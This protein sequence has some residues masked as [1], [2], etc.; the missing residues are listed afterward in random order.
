[1]AVPVD[2]HGVT[3]LRFYGRAE[4]EGAPESP[5]PVIPVLSVVR[6]A[7][8]RATGKSLDDKLAARLKDKIAFVSFD[9]AACER[10]ETPTV[11]SSLAASAWASALDNLL[12]S[13]GLLRASADEDAAVAFVMALLG[14]LVSLLYTRGPHPRRTV[15]FVVAAA[16]LVSVGYLTWMWRSY[17]AGL[18]VGAVIP[19]LAFVVTLVGAT[20]ANYA[21][22][23]QAMGHIR[24][25]MGRYALPTLVEQLLRRPHHLELAGERRHLTAMV[26]DL[27]GF[28]LAADGMS[29]KDVMTLLNEYMAEVQQATAATRGNVDRMSATMAVVYWGAP[30]PNARHALDACRCALK[31]RARLEARLPAWKE[32]VKADLAIRLGVCTGD[33]L[34]GKLSGQGGVRARFAAFGPAMD[35]ASWLARANDGLS[36]TVLVGEATYE[37]VLEEVA[38]REVD[39]LRMPNRPR[40]LRALE[41]RA[42]KREQTEADRIFCD[43]FEQAVVAFRR[44]DFK[45]ALAAFEML[46]KEHPTD[47]PTALYLDRC[48]AYL[49]LPPGDEWDGVYVPR[50]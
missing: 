31:L 38:T 24:E 7:E 4:T 14:A 11:R 33:L 34:V 1:L 16:A 46:A 39:L 50:G 25:A 17:S 26:C 30:L 5:Y 44:R 3:R 22:E 43:R 23:R 21:D 13:D 42:L 19:L 28:T 48:Y 36:T 27:K 6:S 47:R 8:R 12:R 10:T 49:A 20:A 29:P 37:A 45:V 2:A 35:T 15:M 18:W 40:P 41:L 9:V 32:L